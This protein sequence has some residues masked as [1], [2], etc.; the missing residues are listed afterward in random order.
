MACAAVGLEVTG[1]R[2]CDAFAAMSVEGLRFLDAFD[3]DCS[4]GPTL[5]VAGEAATVVPLFTLADVAGESVEFDFL[6]TGAA[7]LLGTINLALK[8]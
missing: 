2:R 5:V 4:L 1:F 3:G 6:R 8:V 7:G